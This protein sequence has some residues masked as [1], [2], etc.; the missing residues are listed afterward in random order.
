MHLLPDVVD[1]LP[2]PCFAATCRDGFPVVQFLGE[3]G[4]A[5]HNGVI[6]EPAQMGAR[7]GHGHRS[8][9]G[10]GVAGQ[11]EVVAVKGQSFHQVPFTFSLKAADIGAAHLA[12][13]LPV[14]RR[15]AF[16]HGLVDGENLVIALLKRHAVGS[17]VGL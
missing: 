7:H 1:A 12:V 17:G 8:G 14:A 4:V 10:V 3:P 13:V 15:N 11:V 16:Q 6:T 2:D 9:S 5:E